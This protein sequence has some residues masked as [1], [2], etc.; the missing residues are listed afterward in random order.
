MV[1]EKE[2]AIYEEL[3]ERE[4]PVAVLAKLLGLRSAKQV[5][6]V[7]QE[8][9]L[10]KEGVRYKLKN[11]TEYIDYQRGLTQKRKIKAEPKKGALDP[12][13]ERAR[14]DSLMADKIEL[15]VQ[16]K[17][18][19]LVD[20]K[21]IETEFTNLVLEVKNKVMALPSRLAPRLEL[22]TEAREIEQIIDKEVRDALSALARGE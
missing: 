21:E 15:E 18:G 16:L 2:Q 17:R 12:E 19:E 1:N 22:E 11:V 20:A 7:V 3:I 8:G 14:K 10:K 5:Q 13:Q 6:N 9:H 4:I